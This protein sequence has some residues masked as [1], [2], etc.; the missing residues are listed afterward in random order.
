MKNCCGDKEV[1]IQ[2][3]DPCCP[4]EPACGVT[5]TSRTSESDSPITWFKNMVP[6]AL[7]F[8]KTE[9]WAAICC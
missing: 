4:P 8:A 7:A 5:D 2:E 1:E 3:T 6:N 9:K